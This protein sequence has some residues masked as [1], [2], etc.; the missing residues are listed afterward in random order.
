MM[1]NWKK[2]VGITAAAALLLPLAACGGNSGSSSS[3]SSS[4]SGETQDVTLTVWSPQEDAKWIAQM[5]S[6]FEKAHPEFKVTWKNSVVSEGDA[7]KTV[8]T[9]PKAAAD[10]YMFANDQLGTLQEAN[11]I[12]PVSSEVEKQVKEQNDQTIIDSVTGTDGKIYGV[13]YTGNTY[14]MYYNKSKFTAD[15]VKSLDT[16]LAKG[17]VA[18]PL[19][20]SWYIPAFYLGAGM[21]MFGANGTDAKDGIKFENA[22]AVT[23]YLVDLVANPNFSNDD[24]TAG[25]ANLTSG[26]ID[27]YFSGSWDSAKVK[28][29]L[30]DNYGAAEMP[31][32]TA[33]GK[34]YQM[35]A[36]A[37]SKAAAF[38]PNAKS[39]KAA[40]TFAAFLGSAE[41]QKAHWEMRE[42][43]PSD[44]TL[45]DL[46]GMKSDPAV[47]AQQ[48]TIQNTSVVQPTI[49][50]MNAWWTPAETF[51][52]SLVSKETN[53]DNYKEKT[54]SWIDSVEKDVAAQTKSE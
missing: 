45:T 36:L 1:I 53:A 17:K 31:K 39:P 6:D 26:A 34:E 19:Q 15:D 49:A 25:L 3:S 13:P 40:S 16:M 32:F 2:A 42:I 7:A 38:N 37:G 44:K 27:A 12:A 21:T 4:A 30:G 11:A 47:A 29:G 54:A 41:A 24:G 23:K 18:Y 35:K 22:D 33:G 14:F 48:A 50:A 51:G 28:E 43:I 5:E 20:N 10:V 52:K 9:D 46:E 8:Q